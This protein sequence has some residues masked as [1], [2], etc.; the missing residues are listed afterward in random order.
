MRLQPI[1]TLSILYLLV[2]TSF[3]SMPFL[4]ASAS[5]DSVT[6][7]KHVDIGFSSNIPINFHDGPKCDFSIF[8]CVFSHFV[9]FVGNA[10]LKIDLGVDVSITYNPSLIVPSGS[11]PVTITYTPTPGGSSAEFDISGSGAGQGL[12]LDFSGCTTA[13]TMLHSPSLQAVRHSQFPWVQILL[14]RFQVSEVSL[15]VSDIIDATLNTNLMLGP[16]P[17]GLFPGLGGAAAIVQVSGATTS[18]VLPIEW[19]SSGASQVV[20]LSL[21]SS[22]VHPIGISLGPLIHWL[23]TSGSV[24]MALHWGPVLTRFTI[25]YG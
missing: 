7:T 9:S 11:L 5:S 15:D 13:P 3:F 22:L 8:A 19:D 16:A 1:F 23:S 6:L 2:L 25:L 24:Q 17:T 4:I 12:T 10:V 20:T 18:Q 21:P 14:Y